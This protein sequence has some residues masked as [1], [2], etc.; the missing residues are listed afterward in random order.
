MVVMNTGHRLN[1]QNVYRTSMVVTVRLTVVT[2]KTGCHVLQILVGVRKGV[3]TD[4]PE[5]SV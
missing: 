3:R 4:G 5:T 2:V 1:V